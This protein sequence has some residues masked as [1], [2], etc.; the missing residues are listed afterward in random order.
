MTKVLHPVLLL[1]FVHVG[2]TEPLTQTQTQSFSISG[3]SGSQTVTFNQFSSSLGEL[4][5]VQLDA[6]GLLSGYFQVTNYTSFWSGTS[7]TISSVQADM[8]LNFGGAG[9]PATLV[10]NTLNDVSPITPV[11]IS[12]GGSAS[13]SVGSSQ[14]LTLTD[15]DLTSFANW[16]TGDATRNLTISNHTTFTAYG[17]SWGAN[18]TNEKLIG[19]ATLTYFYNAPAGPPAVPESSTYGIALGSFALLGVFARRRLRTK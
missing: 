11:Y 6:S 15:S 4:V 3:A 7:T 16:F 14:Y 2:A 8:K 19:S 13:F 12:R 5:G 10:S 18:T 17:G 1:A 9:A